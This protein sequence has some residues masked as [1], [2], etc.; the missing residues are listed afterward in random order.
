[1]QG[2]TASK[3]AAQIL[4]LL[5][6]LSIEKTTVWGCSSGGLVALALA[7]DWPERIRNVVVHEVPAT[8]PSFLLSLLDLNDEDIMK[9]SRKAY[10]AG[11]DGCEDKLHSLGTDYLQRLDQNFVTWVHTYLG[12]V[13]KSWSKEELCR[14]PVTWTIGG[15]HP[16]EMFWQNVVDGFGAG[17]GVG[18][19][20]SKHFPQVTVPEILAEHIIKATEALL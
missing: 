16:A 5:D 12:K 17:V 7:A 4:G 14:R 19:L 6:K 1:M 15:L 8:A 20:P 13:E 3:L 10:V 9:T 2:I 11:F 18:L